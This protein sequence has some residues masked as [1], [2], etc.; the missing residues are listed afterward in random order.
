V[1]EQ[2]GN[3]GDSFCGIAETSPHALQGNVTGEGAREVHWRISRRKCDFFAA[4]RA[5]RDW[6]EAGYKW[7]KR[8]EGGGIEA[9]RDRSR[10]PGT[11]PHAV[12]TTIVDLLRRGGNIRAGGQGSSW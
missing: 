3:I 5:L 2:T 9:L 8:Y 10:A 12:P 6:R 11:H 1:T 4:L 7:R